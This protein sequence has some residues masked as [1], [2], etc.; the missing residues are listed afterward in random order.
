VE[1]VEGPADVSPCAAAAPCPLDALMPCGW[2]LGEVLPE[3]VP[4]ADVASSA[5]SAGGDCGWSCSLSESSSSMTSYSSAMAAWGG[6]G[7]VFERVCV[8]VSVCW[9]SSVHPLVCGHSHPRHSQ[10]P[11]RCLQNTHEVGLT[12]YGQLESPNKHLLTKKTTV[13]PGSHR[14]SCCQRK[15]TCCCCCCCCLSARSPPRDAKGSPV[16]VTALL[17]LNEAQCTAAVQPQ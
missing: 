12:T 15:G 17:L 7:G 13:R 2:C 16:A 10:M 11:V 6:V 5:R 4:R 1:G 14:E 3:A 9:T 8:M